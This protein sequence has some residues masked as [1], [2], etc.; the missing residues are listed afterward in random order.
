MDQDA[1]AVDKDEE[2]H[3][4]EAV[5]REEEHKDVVWQRLGVSIQWVEGV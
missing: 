4:H 5:Q 1:P 2:T 3:V